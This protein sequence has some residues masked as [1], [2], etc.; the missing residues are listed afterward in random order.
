MVDADT[1]TLF[2][3]L[4][5]RLIKSISKYD[6]TIVLV[7][8]V[9]DMSF[10][11]GKVLGKHNEKKYKVLSE[12]EIVN[13]ISVVDNIDVEV[14]VPEEIMY[15]KKIYDLYDFSDNFLVVS[16]ESGYGTLWNLVNNNL[17]TVEEAIEALLR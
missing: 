4:R 5:K 10:S 2:E 13:R 9:S 16:N 14:L 6:A 12:N 8:D 15:L 17:L 3:N 7:E 1:N 11:L